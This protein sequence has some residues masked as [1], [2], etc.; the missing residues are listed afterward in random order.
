MY[1]TTYSHYGYISSSHYGYYGAL[2]TEVRATSFDLRF[3]GPDADDF[4]RVASEQLAGGDVSLTLRN[5]YPREATRPPWP[6]GFVSRRLV[7]CGTRVVRQPRPLPLGCGRLSRR[8][9]GALLVLERGNLP[10]VVWLLLYG[11]ARA[12]CGNFGEHG[13]GALLRRR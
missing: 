3:S 13:L 10:L 11:L 2:S 4:N 12:Q 1:G 9:A 5:V 6:C 7:L 8:H